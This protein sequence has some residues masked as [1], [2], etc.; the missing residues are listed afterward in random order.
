MKC[1]NWERHTRLWASNPTGLG[2]HGQP[3]TCLRLHGLG[4]DNKAPAW[5]PDSDQETDSPEWGSCCRWGSP[6]A[7]AESL[8]C[9]LV[10]Y[11]QLWKA[12]EGSKM[13]PSKALNATAGA[14][15]YRSRLGHRYRVEIPGKNG[16]LVVFPS[17]HSSLELPCKLFH[18]D[19]LWH[20]DYTFK[21]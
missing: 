5:K 15:P 2:G 18:K 17:L 6:E 12:G 14:D 10:V 19:I 16:G 20:H 11:Q 9:E 13:R 1:E 4:K 8:A 3:R 7:D 21:N